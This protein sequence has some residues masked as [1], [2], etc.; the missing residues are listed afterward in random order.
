MDWTF[1]VPHVRNYIVLYGDAYATD[2]QLPLK[3]PPKNPWRPG[4]YITRFPGIPKL[5]LHVDSVSTEQ[6][7]L[8]FDK[9][10]TGGP[11]NAGRFNY[12]NSEYPDGYTNGRNLIGNAVGRDGRNFEAWLTY[13]LS[14]SNSLQLF[15][16]R[17]KVGADFIPGGG[18]WQ[19]YGARNEMHLR[20]GVYMKTELQYQNISRY[21]LL[22]TGPQRNITAIVEIGFTPGEKGEK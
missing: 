17:N 5:D 18:A 9:A 13:W 19:H 7:G 16:S 22:F 21:P 3:N 11:A 2:D 20:S 15:Y 1:Y 14:P 12:W 8:S 10:Y 6:P 4:I